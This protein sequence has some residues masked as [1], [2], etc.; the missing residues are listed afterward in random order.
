MAQLNKQCRFDPTINE[1]IIGRDGFD[2]E[3]IKWWMGA[4]TIRSKTHPV[5]Y[6][7]Y[8]RRFHVDCSHPGQT[9]DSFLNP[10]QSCPDLVASIPSVITTQEP[11]NCGLGFASV[12]GTCYPMPTER[13]TAP[14][15]PDDADERVGLG[16]TCSDGI[17]NDDN[18]LTDSAD[19]KCAEPIPYP[20]P[21]PEHISAPPSGGEDC[22]TITITPGNGFRQVPTNQTDPE[23][24]FSCC[25]SPILIDVSG[26]GFNLTDAASGVD[27][28]LNLDGA[29]MRLSWTSP[30]S[31]DSWLCLDRNGNGTIDNGAELFGNFTPQP[32][33]N[34]PNGF[35]ALAE[36]D[37]A[38]NGGNA[39][40]LINRGDSIFSNLRL[41][42][43]IDHN[44]ISAPDELHTL[45]ALGVAILDI[46]Y[47]KSKRTDQYGNQFRYRAKVKDV[48][49][50]QVGRWAWDVFLVSAE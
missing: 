10:A 31:D 41:W 23:V 21:T 43:D 15:E 28:D 1:I 6:V 4:A 47:K 33:S 46:S 40:G 38:G 50:A 39:D 22:T 2:P 48:H 3:I 42:Q 27:F 37:K 18:G 12:N 44:G 13:L 29:A 19:S 9:E 35:L 5:S 24:C 14:S 30:G 34:T 25:Y 36:Y 7:L 8:D 26:D 16:N 11:N 32:S 49:G 20:T 17:D 45:S